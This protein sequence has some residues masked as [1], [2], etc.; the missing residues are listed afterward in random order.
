MLADRAL[1]LVGRRLGLAQRQR[2]EGAEPVGPGRYDLLSDPGVEPAG[3]GY[4]LGAEKVLRA[5]R[6]RRKHLHVDARLVHVCD[7]AGAE[8]EQFRPAAAAREEALVTAGLQPLELAGREVLLQS[9]EELLPVSGPGARHGGRERP[10]GGCRGDAEA[11]GA[12]QERTPAQGA[13]ARRLPAI[14]V[15]VGHDSK[16][17]FLVIGA[18]MDAGCPWKHSRALAG[19]GA[20]PPR[21]QCWEYETAALPPNVMRRMTSW[22][23]IQRCL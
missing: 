7:P 4:T 23:S 3:E 14:R 8:V 10:G 1:E 15:C 16:L 17:L 6:H 2:G 5:G 12:A 19:G 11:R 21:P 18:V 13:P 20:G 9:D 22:P